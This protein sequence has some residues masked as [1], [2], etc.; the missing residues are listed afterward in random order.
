VARGGPRRF[1]NSSNA[2]SSSKPSLL[3][4]SSA[5]AAQ[6]G[7]EPHRDLVAALATLKPGCGLGWPL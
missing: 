5:A 4:G 7:G 3:A 1:S 2:S 6:L